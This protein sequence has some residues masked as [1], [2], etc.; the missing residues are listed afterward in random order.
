L[1]NRLKSKAYGDAPLNVNEEIW[2]S[3]LES[4]KVEAEE[5]VTS[6]SEVEDLD[7]NE[8]V[9]DESEVELEDLEDII[10]EYEHHEVKNNLSN[11]SIFIGT[12]ICLQ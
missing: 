11:F 7:E 1:I 10:E 8:F 4:N 12:I 5:D 2:R 9:E 3:V 6:E